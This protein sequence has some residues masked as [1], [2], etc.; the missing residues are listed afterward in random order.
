MVEIIKVV[1]DTYG[2]GADKAVPS[3][4]GTFS[5]PVPETGVTVEY[6][7]NSS[8]PCVSSDMGKLQRIIRRDGK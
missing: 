6:W 4:K 2:S 8:K 3:E 5:F 1:R 7:Q